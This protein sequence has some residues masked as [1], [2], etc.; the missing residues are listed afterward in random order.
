MPRKPRTRA[1]I[2]KRYEKLDD[3]ELIEAVC[4]RFCAGKSASQIRDEVEE[5]L[6]R[7]LTREQP[8]QILA[9]AG[10][11]NWLQFTPPLEYEQAQRLTWAYPWLQGV[12]VVMTRTLDPVASR[13][14]RMLLQLIRQTAHD[15]STVHVGLAGGWTVL[16]LVKHFAELL[17][18]PMDDLPEEICFH[19]MV[20]GMQLRYPHTDPNTFY[21]Y[22]WSLP[23][24]PRFV[25]LH[26][27]DLPTREII[28]HLRETHKP[29]Q[30]AFE[31]GEKIDIVVTSGSAWEDEHGLL[32]NL[33]EEQYPDDYKVLLD[34]RCVGDMLWQ[35]INSDGPILGKTKVE[36]MTLKSLDDL[37]DEIPRG[38]KVLLVLGPCGRCATPREDV[39]RTVLNLEKR[40]VTHV[41]TD[42]RSASIDTDSNSRGG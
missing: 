27:P 32:K 11:K 38:L 26:G 35:P 2:M 4:T 13:A 1:A 28:D 33:F 21:N 17:G 10:A 3:M 36:A 29:T 23:V 5:E 19:A 41:V 25:T 24:R 22:L 14:A 40:Y 20:T 12:E 18:Q 9:Y 30:Q 15:K 8:Y 7:S 6:N 42:Y 31:E 37:A 16:Q 39:L 34:A